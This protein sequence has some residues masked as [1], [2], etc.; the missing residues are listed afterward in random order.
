MLGAP[1]YEG[2]IYSIFQERQHFFNSL[3]NFGACKIIDYTKQ[4]F[5]KK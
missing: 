2:S 1:N 4:I 5:D 3:I